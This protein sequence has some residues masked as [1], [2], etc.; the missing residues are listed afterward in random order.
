MCNRSVLCVYFGFWQSRFYFSISDVP[1]NLLGF[2]RQRCHAGPDRGSCR[3]WRLLSLHLLYSTVSDPAFLLFLFS[4]FT[5][6]FYYRVTQLFK[7]TSI[8]VA[9]CREEGRSLADWQGERHESRLRCWSEQLLTYRTS[10]AEPG[11]WACPRHPSWPLLLPTLMPRLSSFVCHMFCTLCTYLYRC[12]AYFFI[13]VY[14]GWDLYFVNT[15]KDVYKYCMLLRVHNKSWCNVN[16][17]ASVHSGHCQQGVPL[18]RNSW[19]GQCSG[20]LR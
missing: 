13:H 17:L 20:A 1:P 19:D 2:V 12:K 4:S 16:G 18:L 14:H 6:D 3:Q 11:G 5:I 10:R 15:P 8:Q 7:S 9:E